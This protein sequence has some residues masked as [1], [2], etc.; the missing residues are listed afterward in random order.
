MHSPRGFVAE[1]QGLA[2]EDGI[3]TDTT[4]E[5]PVD[6]EMISMHTFLVVIA[7]GIEKVYL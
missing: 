2:R 3:P 4:V 6:L 5:P 7:N 1:D